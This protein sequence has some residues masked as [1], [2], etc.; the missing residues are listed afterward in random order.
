MKA[1]QG[2]SSDFNPGEGCKLNKALYGLRQSPR[3][4]FGRFIA[5]MTKF[6]YKLSN[7]DHTLFLKKQ[8]NCIMCLIIYVDDMFI[9]GDDEEEICA[10]KE[11][12]S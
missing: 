2:F 9:T 6:G 7:S 3:A 4:W 1:P 8:N 11:Q 5:T 10:L 12:L